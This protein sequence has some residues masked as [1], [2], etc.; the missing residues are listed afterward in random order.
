MKDAHGVG[1][2]SISLGTPPLFGICRLSRHYPGCV[3]RTSTLMQRVPPLIRW[4]MGGLSDTRPVA[5]VLG[6]N[7]ND[8]SAAALGG[9]EE[10]AL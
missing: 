4:V 6:P 10:D 8:R 3:V 1:F 5:R 7:L 9:D 2:G